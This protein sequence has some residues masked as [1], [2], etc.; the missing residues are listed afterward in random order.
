VFA[1]ARFPNFL[2]AGRFFLHQ[3][4]PERPTVALQQPRS[5]WY[6][7]G[8]NGPFHG[9]FPI[10][11]RAPYLGGRYPPR[12]GLFAPRSRGYFCKVILFFSKLAAS[13]AL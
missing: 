9:L 5:D 1:V 10:Q 2:G 13:P 8:V 4:N 3:I 7:F 6:K 12:E 11:R